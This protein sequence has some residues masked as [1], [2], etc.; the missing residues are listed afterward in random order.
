MAAMGDMMKS[1][2]GAGCGSGAGAPPLMSGILTLSPADE[3]ARRAVAAESHRRMDEGASLSTRAAQ[4]ARWAA[5]M[6]DVATVEQASA[7]LREGEQLFQSG[8]AAHLALARGPEAPAAALDWFRGQMNLPTSQ[9][10]HAGGVWLG[11]TPAHLLLMTA[12]SL[13]A[14][15]L[16]GLQLIRRSRVRAILSSS[17]PPSASSAKAAGG[18]QPAGS[19]PP[20]RE[21]VPRTPPIPNDAPLP[22]ARPGARSRRWSGSLRLAQVVRETP[23]VSTFRLVDPGGGLLPFDFA[24]GQFLQ[25]EVEPTP[26]RPIKRSYTIASS[27]TRSAYVELTVKREAQGVVSAFLHDKVKASDLVKVSGPV[28]VFTFTGSDAES[29]V[30]IAGGVGITPMM[31]V[32]RYLTDLT[33]PGIIFFIYSARSPEE[34]VFREEIEYLERRHPNLHTL[35]MVEARSPGTSWLGPEGVLTKELLRNEVPEIG[36]RR[37]HLCGPPAMM[38]VVK[39]LL[40]ELGVPEAQIKTEAFGPASLPTQEPTADEVA[41]APTATARPKAKRGKSLEVAANT[42][43]FS[44]AGVAAALAEDTTVLEA[45]E[46]AGVEIPFSCRVGTCGVC[47]VKLAHG[48]VTMAVEEGLA[49]ED[50]AQ[51]FVLACQAKSAGG[52]L[53]IEA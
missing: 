45:A 31:S 27:P 25:V 24:P 30:L 35:I 11:A 49:P 40:T 52:D 17:Q 26:G 37:V 32:L 8:A 21:P 5:S 33:W 3:A 4:Q 28:G 13:V 7:R 43:T 38:T 23:T 47:V 10:E 2:M 34:V 42:V 46:G 29:I 14:A 19:V 41:T 6:R 51:G 39:G 22:T 44:V 16:L 53:V 18:A 50:K 1:C 20:A 12:L 36:A 48:Q 9:T 15:G